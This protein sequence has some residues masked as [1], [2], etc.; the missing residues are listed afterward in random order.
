MTRAG[1]KLYGD[2]NR[3][4]NRE[5]VLSSRRFWIGLGVMLAVMAAVF[6]VVG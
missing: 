1:E 2:W 5:G 4:M 3:Q 6:G